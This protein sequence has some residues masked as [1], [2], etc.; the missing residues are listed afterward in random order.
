M[1]MVKNKKGKCFIDKKSC[2]EECVL[3][4]KGL[5]Y[6]DDTRP[7]EPFEE[8]A[9]NIIA[10]GVENIISRTVGLQAEQNKV[11]NSIMNVSVILAGALKRRGIE[12]EGV[13]VIDN[14]SER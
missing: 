6:F 1:S 5:R 7:P 2:N 8:C 4:R 3:Y 10:D 14:N 11:A 13:Y 12:G 9:I